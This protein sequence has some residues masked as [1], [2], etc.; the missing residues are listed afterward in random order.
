MASVR[1]SFGIPTIGTAPLFRHGKELA[2]GWAR[3]LTREAQANWPPTGRFRHDSGR[4]RKGFVGEA[5][6]TLALVLHNVATTRKGR[7]YAEYIHLAGTPR[8]AV[9]LPQLVA[10]LEPLVVTPYL[11]A[12]GRDFLATR[13]AATPRIVR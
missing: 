12:L 2:A 11:Q 10:K 4:S 1:V 8:S 6:A 7:S 3:V 13:R 5:T 9:L